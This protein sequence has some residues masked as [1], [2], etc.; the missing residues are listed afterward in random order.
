MDELKPQINPVEI[1]P[2][3]TEEERI[4][5]EDG[6]DNSLDA[7]PTTNNDIDLLRA[8]F[9]LMTDSRNDQ[10]EARMLWDGLGRFYF[11]REGEEG[12]HA[13][14]T[15]RDLWRLRFFTAE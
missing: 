6:F 1:E 9:D 7:F 5:L 13:A 2:L 15:I 4:E 12:E 11:P 3:F 8:L 10:Q 14:R